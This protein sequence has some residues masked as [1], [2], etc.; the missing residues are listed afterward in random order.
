MAS[1]ASLLANTWR[2]EDD[3]PV[4]PRDF[5]PWL[6]QEDD[7]EQVEPVHVDAMVDMLK[8]V[9]GAEEVDGSDG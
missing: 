5:M 7:D 4:Q 3:E 2:G 9:F 8:R 6:E 1:I